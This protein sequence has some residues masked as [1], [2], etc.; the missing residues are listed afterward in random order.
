[1]LESAQTVLFYLQNRNK[2]LMSKV[3][4]SPLRLLL[5]EQHS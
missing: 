3:C 4:T 2:V 1:M 5:K